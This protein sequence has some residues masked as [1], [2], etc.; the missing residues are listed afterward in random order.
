M[1]KL[2]SHTLLMSSALLFG[3]TL[4]AQSED[5]DVDRQEMAKRHEEIAAFHTK[6]AACFAG[7]EALSEC[8]NI[9]TTSCPTMHGKMMGWMNRGAGK[10]S[11]AGMMGP[12][13]G[14]MG[15]GMMGQV[16][17]CPFQDDVSKPKSADAINKK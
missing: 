6:I 1:L 4:S 16:Y 11:R 8:Q 10:G 3:G 2:L 5:K 9:M 12:K 14:M 15:Q 13:N 7:N 17:G